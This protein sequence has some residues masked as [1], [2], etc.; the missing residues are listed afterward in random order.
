MK[1]MLFGAVALALAAPAAAFWTEDV[2][3]ALDR[4]HNSPN[5]KRRRP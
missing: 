2:W 4:P 1:A 3:Q 5:P